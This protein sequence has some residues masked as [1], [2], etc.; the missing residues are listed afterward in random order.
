MD[1]R[2]QDSCTTNKNHLSRYFWVSYYFWAGG[3]FWESC[4]FWAGDY[5]WPGGYTWESCYFGSGCYFWAGGYFWESCY[6]GAGCYFWAGGYFWEGCYFGAGCYFGGWQLLGEL[7]LRCGLL[8]L[9]GRLGPVPIDTLFVSLAEC[10]HY[11]AAGKKNS[12][13]GYTLFRSCCVSSRSACREGLVSIPTR[14]F[15]PFPR[16]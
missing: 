15:F 2:S 1:F 8:L 9:G 3:Y 14:F 7:L 5:F 13:D 4:R 12:S 6:F 11:R 16:G 10:H